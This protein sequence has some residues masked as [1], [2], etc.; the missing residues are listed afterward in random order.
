M[1][2]IAG[3][4]DCDGRPFLF[5][6]TKLSASGAFMAEL[7]KPSTRRI[8]TSSYCGAPR[9]GRSRSRAS[10]APLTTGPPLPARSA[11]PPLRC[12]VPAF[13]LE[14]ARSAA[15]M[16]PLHPLFCR[17]CRRRRPT[18]GTRAAAMLCPLLL[19]NCRPPHLTTEAAGSNNG[20]AGADGVPS[21]G[22]L[23]VRPAARSSA[24]PLAC[25]PCMLPLHAGR[26][27]PTSVVF[28]CCSLL[29]LLAALLCV[30]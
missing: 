26:P 20:H 11:P 9:I 29:F 23:V 13:V 16:L 5:L 2:L 21:G 22:R 6:Q 17:R 19:S 27:L 1:L 28:S 15:P 4:L 14:A 18:A 12:R 24:C 30:A 10:T 7:N 8:T 3:F 25:C